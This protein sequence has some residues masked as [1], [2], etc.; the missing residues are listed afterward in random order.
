MSQR[1]SAAL[2]ATA[3][4]LVLSRD[5]IMHARRRHQLAE[6]IHFKMFRVLKRRDIRVASAL[7]KLHP[8]VN[9][10]VRFAAPWR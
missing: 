7:M 6:V 5:A 2:Q 3:R 4:K 10:A 9:V 1:K 8:G